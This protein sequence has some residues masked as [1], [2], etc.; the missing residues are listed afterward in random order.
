MPTI[1]LG[2]TFDDVLILPQESN[3]EAATAD[4]TT[5]LTKR[6]KLPAPILSAAM[7]TVTTVP[8]ARALAQEGGLGVLH[9]NCTVAEQVAM[10]KAVRKSNLMVGAA[11]GP[12]DH[13]R[14]LALD[15]A[16]A[17]VIVLDAAH[18]HKPQ[19]VASARTLKRR[20][21]AELIV[22]NVATATAARAYVSFVDAIKVGV[23]PGA[24][25]TT[26]IIAGVGVPQLTAIMDVTRVART[27]NVPVIADGGMKY[28]GD[29]VKA[30]AA[31]A[32]AVMLGSMLAGTDEA[33][34]ET[35][36]ING[37]RYKRYRGMGSLGAMNVG[38][39]S[40][41]YAQAGHKK[42]VPEGVEGLTRTKGPLHD[43][44]FQ[45]LGGLRS[46][47]GYVGARTIPELQRR[48]KFIQITEAGR[49]ESHPHSITIDTPAPNY[50]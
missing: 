42:Y 28:S 27:K 6:L 39:S 13:D 19:T 16:G 2:L 41:R 7:D 11:V 17:S 1:P 4:L 29:V 50:S 43:V 46:G 23:G 5:Q 10:V 33:P 38:Q 24:I 26:R 3:I 48:A 32:N 8:L 25:C 18:I 35:V 22:G 9:R 49:R 34:G 12:F 14:A 21:R 30:L 45:I 44:V 47:M 31:G 20:L 37:Q 36:T 40:D 15:Q